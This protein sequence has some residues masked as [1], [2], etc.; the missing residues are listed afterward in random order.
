[1]HKILNFFSSSAVHFYIT[2]SEIYNRIYVHFDVASQWHS[3]CYEQARMQSVCEDNM[4]KPSKVITLNP[5]YTNASHIQVSY[6]ALFTSDIG[7]VQCVT[8][9]AIMEREREKTRSIF[10]VFILAVVFNS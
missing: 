8:D 2:I 4:K 5:K 1:M 3:K 10:S 7:H 9:Y 6:L